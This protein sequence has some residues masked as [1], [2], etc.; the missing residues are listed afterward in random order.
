M[1]H[2]LWPTLLLV[3]LLFWLGSKAER[4]LT[5]SAGRRGFV[6]MAI[7][8]ASPGILFAAY[9]TKLLGEPIWL[10]QF[11][12]MPRTE[13]AAAG[14]GLLAGFIHQVRHKH[15]T[16]KKQFRAL[17]VPAILAV[18]I[19]AP[20]VKPLIRPLNRS[21]LT[22][23]WKDDVCLQST[24]ST[25]GPASAATI[26]KSL[27]KDVKEAE[28]AQ[29]S[30]TYAGGTENWYLTRALRKRG[31]E[32]EFRPVAPESTE[33]PTSA[34][35]GV[36][37]A[38]GTGHFIALISKEGTSYIASDPLTGRFTA[39]LAELKSTYQFTGFFLVIK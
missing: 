27:G 9:Y 37:L 14:T 24:P 35:A 39:T 28:L 13:L 16:L 21:L 34:V 8:L 17:T 33:F 1:N 10:Y 7:A 3:T 5:S 23:Q 18:L 38:Q 32:V 4:K 6:L 29:E 15:P 11:R 26:L 22:E 31:F 36:K 25:C 12:A 2:M 19:C 20:Y 30:L